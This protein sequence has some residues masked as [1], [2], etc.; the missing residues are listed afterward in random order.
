MLDT[1]LNELKILFGRN[2]EEIIDH[3]IEVLVKMVDG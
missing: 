1:F 3:E 2:P